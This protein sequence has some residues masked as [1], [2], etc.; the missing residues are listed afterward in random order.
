MDIARSTWKELTAVMEPGSI[1]LLPIGSTEPH[2]PHLALDTDVTIARA[3]AERSAEVLEQ[4]GITAVVLPALPYGVTRFAGDFPG[5]ISLRP[6]TLWAL[7]E[8]LILTLE[9][10]GVR[11]IVFCNAHLEPEHIEVIRGV[12][13]DHSELGPTT[14]QAIF[15]DHT[16]RKAAAR[17]SQ[18]F[19][20][21]E[22]HAGEYETSIVQAVD[23]SAVRENTR[24]LLPPVEIGLIDGIAQG[25]TT[26]AEMGAEECYCGDPAAATAAHGEQQLQVLASIVTDACRVAWPDLFS[27]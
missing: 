3:Q 27:S 9:E 16:R 6:G 10:V 23:P 8:D 12:V 24:E 1:F 21:G 5:A 25:K 17:L 14:A 26:F 22:C 18:E 4:A 19:Q 20:S 15:P 11:R 2:G 7:L 13:L